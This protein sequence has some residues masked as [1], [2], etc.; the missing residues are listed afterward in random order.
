VVPPPGREPEIGFEEFQRIY[1]AIRP[2]SPAE[3]ARLL[4]GAP[5]R[6]W[7]AGGWSVELGREPRRPHEDIEI[8]VPRRDLAALRQWLRDYHLWDTFEGGLHH[9]APGDALADDRDQL[10]LRRDAYSPWIADLMLTPVDGDTWIYKRDDRVQRPLDEVIRSGTDGVPY[11]RPEVTLLY[12][13]RRRLQ[14]DEQDFAAVLPLLPP[15]DRAWLRD[16][17]ASTEPGDNPWLDRLA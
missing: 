12:K 8:G 2:L 6:W 7:I 1:G 15:A 17:I 11:Q 4:A 5:F 13:A 3:A 10:W 9:L 14:K 16:A